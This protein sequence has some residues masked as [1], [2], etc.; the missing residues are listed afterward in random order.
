VFVVGICVTALG[1][2]MLTAAVVQFGRTPLGEPVT[3]GLYRV[4]RHPQIVAL[5]VSLVG[6]G[7]TVGSWLVLLLLLASRV[8]Q[9]FSIVAE[10]EACLRAYGESYQEYLQRVPRY[11]VVL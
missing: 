5:F 7:L 4:S 8:L 6:A 10:E 2:A 1:I 9:H 3:G 11:F